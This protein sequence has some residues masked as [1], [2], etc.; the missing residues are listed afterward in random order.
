MMQQR[1][2]D[3]ARSRE[4]LLGQ[5]VHRKPL[6]I[7]R[8]ELSEVEQVPLPRA[9]RWPQFAGFERG[10]FGL[11][12]AT[13]FFACARV[14]SR[15][16]AEPP[17]LPM[18]A[19]YSRTCFCASVM[20]SCARKTLHHK[21]LTMQARPSSDVQRHVPGGEAPLL[22]RR[23]EVRLTSVMARGAGRPIE[24]GRFT[25]EPLLPAAPWPSLASRRSFVLC[26]DWIRAALSLRC[27]PHKFPPWASL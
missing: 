26:S 9:G 11:R 27:R 7:Q 4:E 21:R 23:P 17:R 22:A 24:A 19:R 6:T 10:A 3:C 13:I 16:P 2:N 5:V 12:M 14:S 1:M 15:R 20:L 18:R 8:W 25:S